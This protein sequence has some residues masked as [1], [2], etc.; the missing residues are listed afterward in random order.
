VRDT[1]ALIVRPEQ[2]PA[3][4]GGDPVANGPIKSG[5]IPSGAV[6]IPLGDKW[7]IGLAITSPFSFVTKYAP[8]SWTRYSALT[9]HLTTID[10]Q[11]SIAFAPTPWLRLG[12]AANAERSNAELSN[13]L[14]N[15]SPLLP[16][17]NETLTGNGW[18]WGWSAGVQAHTDVVTVGLSYKSSIDHQLNGQAVV[19]GL[20]GPA[21]GGDGAVSTS[22]SFRTPWQLIFG[23]R[24]KVTPALTLNA[25]AVRAGWSEF[26]AIQ[27]GAPVNQ[28][29]PEGY[30]DT[31]TLAFGADYAICPRWTLRGG[32]QYDQTPTQNGARDARVPDADRVDLAVGASFEASKA[33]TIDAGLSYDMFQN[34]SI[35]RPTA[36]F[37]GTPLQ[38]PVLTSGELTGAHALILALGGRFRF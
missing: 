9:T 3:G 37:V 14:P 23:A 15:V 17:G 36:A 18:N 30:K 7:A 25:Q 38:T 22:A 1:G 2:P 6:A 35:D 32:V 34:A 13:A 28:A 16:D 31:W 19:T 8:N 21:A 12:V 26:N 33:V 24:F 20:L 10:L 11:P 5:V 4:V 29:L 27:I